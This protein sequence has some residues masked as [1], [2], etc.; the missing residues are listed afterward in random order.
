MAGGIHTR[1]WS[2]GDQGFPVILIHG[3]GGSV[4]IWMHN[5]EAL[6]EQHRVY[7][8]DLPGFGRSE[9][10]VSSFTPSDY[11]SFIDD[12][13]KALNVDRV[14]LIGQS[15]GGGIALQYAL[16]FPE[17]VDKLVLVDG[18]GL[19]KEVIWTL[20]IMSLP[21]IGELI[22]HPSRIGVALFFKLAVRNRKLINRDF[23]NLYYQLFTQPGFSAFLL[24][25]V[26]KLVDIHGAKEEFLA[27]I[28][29]NLSRIIQPTLI[30]WGENDRVLPIRHAYY[31]KEKIVN[32]H[33]QIVKQCGHIP[34][35]ERADEFNKLVLDFLSG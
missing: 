2:L 4:E 33:L 12:F 35:F 18:A 10:P 7:A 22:S 32:S 27:P 8:P 28:M 24:K 11:I 1:F 29:E 16:Q 30:I 19:G 15:L 5:I 13:R 21:L 14:S 3:L 6:A 34:N 20:R 31:G 17:K 23:I 9:K 26:R 25:V